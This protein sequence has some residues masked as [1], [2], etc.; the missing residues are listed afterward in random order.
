MT[1]NQML[2]DGLAL[3]SALDAVS[4]GAGTPAQVWTPVGNFQSFLALV[5]VGVM[6][7]GSTVDFQIQQAQDNAGTGAKIIGTKSITQLLAAGGNNRQAMVNCRATD[8]DQ[9]N[10]FS[11]ISFKITVGT[12]ASLVAG[13]LL[14]GYPRFEPVKDATANPAINLGAASVAQIV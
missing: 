10:G 9:L 4:Q 14:G 3:I 13:F 2:S 1:P 8:L 12:A 11:F 5:D 6:Q 7:A